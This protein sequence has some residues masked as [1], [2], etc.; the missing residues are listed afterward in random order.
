MIIGLPVC[1]RYNNP[2]RDVLWGLCVNFVVESLQLFFFALPH[3]AC[4]L[5][6]LNAAL[7][8]SF[9]CFQDAEHGESKLSIYAE[10]VFPFFFFLLFFSF[11]R[12]CAS[13]RAACGVQVVHSFFIPE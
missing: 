5:P 10:F 1:L 2:L 4:R 7:N 9:C 6:Y 8:G 3:H 13:P 12:M 11:T